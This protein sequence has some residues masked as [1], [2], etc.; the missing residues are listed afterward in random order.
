V[1]K[2]TF[3]RLSVFAAAVSFAFQVPAR[4][5][6]ET[7]YHLK[8]ERVHAE[9]V[10]RTYHGPDPEEVQSGRNISIFNAVSLIFAVISIAFLVT[11]GVR[12]EPGWYSI[13]ILI[14]LFTFMSYT[15][16]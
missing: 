14:L 15:L 1:K 5:E 2:R 3:F 16:L 10:Q 7:Y 13:P 9:I 4:G 8:A 12:H 6:I 11:A